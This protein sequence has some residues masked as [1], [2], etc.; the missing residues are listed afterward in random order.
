MN[1]IEK[2]TQRI[3]AEARAEI[4]KML[5]DARGAAAQ[6]T[7]K[8]QAQ[9]DREAAELAERNRKAA[10]QREERLVSVSQMEARKVTLGAKQEMVEKA[11]AA[12]LDKLCS[13]SD[14]AYVETVAKL[15]R[16][17]AP[18]G[19]GEV[20][21]SQTDRARIGAK[22]VEKANG[23]IGAKAALTLSDQGRPIRGGFIL[24]CGSVEI[25]CTFETLVRLQKGETAGEVAKQLFPE[26]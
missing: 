2:I 8:Y 26:G 4:D 7:A 5:A 9:A 24:V 19:R 16:Q 21:F 25:N 3:D 17:A 10:E 23:L 15:L 22:A 12:A 11:F 14:E 13:L 20:I 6:V 18:D 1:G